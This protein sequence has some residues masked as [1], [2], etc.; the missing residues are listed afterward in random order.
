MVH[1]ITGGPTLRR[2]RMVLGWFVIYL[3][4]KEGPFFGRE[5]LGCLWKDLEKKSD[6]LICTPNIVVTLGI[7]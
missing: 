1:N 5:V 2:F 4:K 6:Q 7:N 3:S